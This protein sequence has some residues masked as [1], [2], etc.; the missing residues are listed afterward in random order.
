MYKNYFRYN[1][2]YDKNTRTYR[3]AVNL[4]PDGQ[5]VT[6]V[7]FKLKN[8]EYDSICERFKLGQ[9]AGNN[10]IET[11]ENPILTRSRD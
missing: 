9:E 11:D 3:K 7:I 5:M 4:K 10:Y 1:S 2:Y 6:V 8:Q